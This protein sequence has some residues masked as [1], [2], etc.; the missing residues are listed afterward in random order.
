MIQIMSRLFRT[1]R[2]VCCAM[3]PPR[4]W[5][6]LQEVELGM[7]KRNELWFDKSL[8]LQEDY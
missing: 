7:R 1:P 3:L 8:K 6:V 2:S 4:S 5:T